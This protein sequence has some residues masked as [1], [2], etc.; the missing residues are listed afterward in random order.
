MFYLDTSY[1]VKCYLNEPGSRDVLDWIEGK[2]GLC[3]SVH[4][5]LEFWSALCRHRRE[6]RISVNEFRSVT[7]S[8]ESDEKR[9]VWTWLGVTKEII[10]AACATVESIVESSRLRSADALHL[11]CAAEHGFKT[12]YSHDKIVVDSA[13]HFGLKGVDIIQSK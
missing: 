4:G 12:V 9:S 13:P 5:R 10:S 1:L 3:C 2:T 6:E 11:A 7:S 8:F